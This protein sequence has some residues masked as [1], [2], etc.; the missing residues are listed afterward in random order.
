MRPFSRIVGIRVTPFR[1]FSKSFHKQVLRLKSIIMNRKMI[2][3]F[4][5]AVFALTVSTDGATRRK[6]VKEGNKLYQ[7]EK[8]DRAL[9]KYIEAMNKGELPEIDFNAGNAHYK[10]GNFDRAGQVYLKALNGADDNLKAK[11]FFNAGNTLLKSGDMGNAVSAYINSLKLNPDDMEVKQ[12]LEYA[13]RQIQQQQQQQQEQNQDEQQQKQQLQDQENQQE[14]QS[15]PE[16]SEQREEQKAQL[17]ENQ[18]EE[19][20]SEEDVLKILNALMNDEKAVQEKVIKQRMAG[21]K[22]KDK[23]W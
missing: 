4:T 1:D 22:S 6:L 11:V 12:N 7:Q 9:V 21:R 13:L 18:I 19:Q 20:M 17:Q 15:K 23:K 10:A 5:L 16:E 8:F 2:F 14:Q 3:V